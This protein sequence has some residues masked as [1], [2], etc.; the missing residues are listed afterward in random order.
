MAVSM[1]LPRTNAYVSVSDLSRG[2]TS[3]AIDR[4]QDEPVF[5]LNHNRPVAVMIGVDE[6]EALLDRLEDLEDER[7]AMDRL[8][9]WDGS[10]VVSWEESL[11]NAGL[12]Q[13]DIDAAPEVEFE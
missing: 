12:T 1:T 13:A 8:D 9:H 3:E 7:L 11:R 4:A 5:V 6:Y 10:T 2:G